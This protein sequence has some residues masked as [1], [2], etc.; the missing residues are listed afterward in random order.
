MEAGPVI[1]TRP[2]DTVAA[3][4]HKLLRDVLA[5]HPY[6]RSVLGYSPSW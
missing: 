5:S 3:G 6:E 1:P 4:Y 2:N